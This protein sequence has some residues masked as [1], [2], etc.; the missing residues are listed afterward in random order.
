MWIEKK[1]EIVGEDIG[2]A[3]L[4]HP[5]N[6]L[7][8]K[9]INLSLSIFCNKLIYFLKKEYHICWASSLIF[10]KGAADDHFHKLTSIQNKDDIIRVIER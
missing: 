3:L 9:Q 6:D 5:M 1:K 2:V 4:S 8:Y 10:F 7:L